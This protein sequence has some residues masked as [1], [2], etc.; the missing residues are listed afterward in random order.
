MSKYYVQQADIGMPCALNCV[1][2]ALKSCIVHLGV[3]GHDPGL[4]L[5]LGLRVMSLQCMTVTRYLGQFRRI[6]GCLAC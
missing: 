6:S 2:P 4:R 5:R 3:H 1:G